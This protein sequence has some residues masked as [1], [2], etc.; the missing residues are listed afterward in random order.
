MNRSRRGFLA[1]LGGF[2]VLAATNPF[3]LL[4]SAEAAPAP[5]PEPIVELPPAASIG[6]IESF[7]WIQYGHA[8]PF[9]D[10]VLVKWDRTD[11]ISQELLEQTR[12][13][14]D[15]IDAEERKEEP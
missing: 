3:K 10:S 2:A 7:R 11:P 8:V 9:D 14:F 13:I 4:T 15:A 1:F 5:V 12:R 6:H